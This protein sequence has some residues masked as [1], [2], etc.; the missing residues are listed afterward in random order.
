MR[1]MSVKGQLGWA[2]MNDKLNLPKTNPNRGKD[3]DMATN[4]RELKDEVQRLT[5][6]NTMVLDALREV[7]YYHPPTEDCDEWPELKD[8]LKR[9]RKVTS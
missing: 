7:L 8:C 4:K 9:A 6:Y 2:K 3:K 1:T 5:T